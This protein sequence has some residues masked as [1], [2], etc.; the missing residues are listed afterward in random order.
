MAERNLIKLL[1][2][3]DSLPLR[4]LP[5]AKAAASRGS[6]GDNALLI[7]SSNSKHYGF[8]FRRLCFW[9]VMYHMCARTLAGWLI[10]SAR[11]H[12]ARV[13]KKAIF[14]V[15]PFHSVIQWSNTRIKTMFWKIIDLFSSSQVCIPTAQ[16]SHFQGKPGANVGA[17]CRRGSVYRRP[18]LWSSNPGGMLGAVRGSESKPSQ[19]CQRVGMN[20]G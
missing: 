8:Q 5:P 2:Y 16:K 11:E 18:S 14:S 1:E 15:S 12:F 20:T 10:S 6:L 9:L 3:D 13:I 4:Q 19:N 17:G 7:F